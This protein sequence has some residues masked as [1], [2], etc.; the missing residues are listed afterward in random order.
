MT[1]E[2]TIFQPTE[3]SASSFSNPGMRTIQDARDWMADELTAMQKATERRDQEQEQVSDNQRKAMGG[4]ALGQT[5][6]V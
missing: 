4:L 2:R 6:P 3:L 5:S 1:K